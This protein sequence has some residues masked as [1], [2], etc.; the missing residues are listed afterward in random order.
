MNPQLICYMAPIAVEVIKCLTDCC[1]KRNSYEKDVALAKITDDFKKAKMRYEYEYKNKKLD[2]QKEIIL[3]MF[4]L[5]RHIM[6]GKLNA[7]K[8]SS[9]KTRSIFSNQIKLITEEELRLN[10]KLIKASKNKD[11]ASIS[12]RI[13]NLQMQKA[14][15]NTELR[16]L[17]SETNKLIASLEIPEVLNQLQF[18]IKTKPIPMLPT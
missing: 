9:E 6:D 3:E 2:A 16:I 17:N 7:I 15:L 14:K 5:I 8:E 4:K 12:K 13:Y 18:L 1:S 11:F 10:D